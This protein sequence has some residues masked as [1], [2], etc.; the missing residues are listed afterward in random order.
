M[1]THSAMTLLISFTHTHTH[2]YVYVC[3]YVYVDISHL[4]C[5]MQKLRTNALQQAGIL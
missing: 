3:V 5:C 2:V 4:G 1:K